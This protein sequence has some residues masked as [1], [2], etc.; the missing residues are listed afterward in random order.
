MIKSSRA[1]YYFAD[2]VVV[3]AAYYLAFYMRL[4]STA[5]KG[6]LE[7][8]L[9]TLGPAVLLML[10]GLKISGVYRGIWRYTSVRDLL[11]LIRGCVY[12]TLGFVP[13]VVFIWGM[14]GYPRSVFLIYGFLSV[15]LLGASRMARRLLFE[16]GRVTRKVGDEKLVLVVGAGDAASDLLRELQRNA[17]L[18]LQAVGL[19]DDNRAKVG[20]ELHGVKVLGVIDDIPSLVKDN[21]VQE[22]LIAIASASGEQMRRIIALCQKTGVPYRTLP[23]AGDILDGKVQVSQLRKV[24]ID[25]LLRR[26]PI[27]LDRAAIGHY[28]TGKRV[29]VTGAGGSIGSEI[30]RQVARY[31]PEEIIFL[32]HSENGLFYIEEEFARHGRGVR[33]RV[34][35][36]DVTNRARMRQVMGDTK[37]DV[38]FHA[39]AHKHVYLM[40]RNFWEAFRNNVTGTRVAAEAAREAGVKKFVMISTDKAVNPTSVMGLSKRIA[41]LAI[42]GLADDPACGTEF[43]A[44]RFGNVMASE[45]SVI[46]LWQ[47][48]IKAGGPVTV[49]HAEVV[50]YFMTIPEAVQLVLQAAAMGKGREIF[51]LDMGEPVKVLDLARQVIELSG[52]VPDED[53]EIKIIGLRPG[54]KLYEEL[55]TVGE[56]IVPTEHE[57][58]LVLKPKNDGAGGEMLARIA[59][60]EDMV[61]RCAPAAEILGHARGIV[62]FRER[63][64]SR[65][66]GSTTSNGLD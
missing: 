48:Q 60:L 32:D 21:N 49:T 39:A 57:K 12:G 64:G 40:E 17:R 52:L 10:A 8:F 45:G 22:I 23:G 37:P 11:N 4:E 2:A 62:P 15:L 30:C 9:Q 5:L 20:M 34:V 38:V 55:I 16:A 26:D 7:V 35:V 3:A 24:D 46:P 47:R 41:E 65:L 59:V 25:D 29:L 53:I 54:E 1:W 31:S 27:R 18:A 14:P 33:L 44:V 50:R 51:I 6:H 28:L 42:Q 56:G 61:Y 43:V 13:A 19:V 58:I 63:L 36:A 66:L